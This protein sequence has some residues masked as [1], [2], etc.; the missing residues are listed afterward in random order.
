MSAQV[1]S[2]LSRQR[3]TP[4]L[5]MEG[6]KVGFRAGHGLREVV[7]GVSLALREAEFAALVGESGS[8][9]TLTA[10]SISRLLP[11][12]CVLSQGR[13]LFEGEDLVTASE[14]R[15]RALRG[16]GF[17]MVFQDPLAGL[18]PLHRVGRQIHEALAAHDV[19]PEKERENRVRELL[20]LVA[21]REHERVLRSFPH[22]LSG[23]Q[24]QRVLL[25]MALANNPR[26]LVAD[27]PTTA[28]DAQVQLD[29]LRLME[30][31]RERLGMAILLVTHD[32]ALVRRFA[33]TVHVMRKGRVV[34]RGPT[35]AVFARQR[36][37][38]TRSLLEIPAFDEKADI[39]K[40]EV[41][42]DVRDLNV[43]FRGKKRLFGKKG[44][45]FTAVRDVSFTLCRNE[46]LGLV[47]ESGSGKTSLGMA[48]LRLVP[49]SGAVSFLGNDM[50]ALD[51][52]SLRALRPRMQ[53]VFQDPFS[54]LNPR[55]NLEELVC[56]GVEAHAKG[57][58]SRGERRELATSALED[59]DLDPRWVSRYPRELSGGQRQRVAIARALVMK[60]DLLVL[61]EP[62]SSLDRNLQFQ[63]L[64]LLARVQAERRMACLF[65]THDL[66]LVRG[67]CHNVLVLKDG[68]CVEKNTARAIF[69]HPASACARSLVEAFAA[70]PETT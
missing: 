40:N 67:F 25:T 59:V 65:I 27:E 57:G 64:E 30:S 41:V 47:G 26:L 60:P 32:L 16:K 23:G 49:S 10:R 62:T 63:I 42:L 28:L 20:D 19:C 9:K 46:C 22:E 69:E 6:L 12:G 44:Q 17:G 51:A 70:Q 5:S 61:D 36:H 48:I 35:R 39:D 3:P 66:R 38:Y 11:A 7:H 54:S 52:E 55:M 2:G 56:E 29:I 24:R 1:Q 37:P 31:L 18:N 53:V 45:E 8:G 14:A 34:E 33:D 21:L 4:L 43:V 58:L 50:Q 68:V 13:V 15:M